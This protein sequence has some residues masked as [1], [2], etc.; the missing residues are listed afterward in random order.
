MKTLCLPLLFLF[1]FFQLHIGIAQNPESGSILYVHHAATGLNDGSS[2]ENAFV[3]LQTAIQAVD[4]GDQLWVAKGT[5]LPG[6]MYANPDS[7][8]FML[9]DGVSLYGGFAGTEISLAERDIENNPTILSGD[10][11]GDDVPG[12]FNTNRED[13]CIHVLWIESSIAA[14]TILDGFIIEGGHTDT[15][16]LQV[17]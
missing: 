15:N 8:F 5:Y 6:D 10:L 12:E 11:N 3:D 16:P 9:S 13:N 7:S 4:Y 2:W 1:S 14:E 17:V